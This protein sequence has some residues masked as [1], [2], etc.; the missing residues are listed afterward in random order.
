LSTEKVDNSGGNAIRG[1]KHGRFA[2][3]AM[4]SHNQLG[5]VCYAPIDE[6][7]DRALDFSCLSSRT[8]KAGNPSTNLGYPFFILLRTQSS[9]SSYPTFEF[10]VGKDTLT[11]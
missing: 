7:P 3:L 10:H 5:E 4:L 2:D 9:P 6:E 8:T 1:E 11:A